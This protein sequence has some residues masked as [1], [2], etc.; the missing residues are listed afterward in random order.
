MPV[1]INMN[2]KLD[3]SSNKCNKSGESDTCCESDTCGEWEMIDCQVD[4]SKQKVVKDPF[5]WDTIRAE[6]LELAALIP[7]LVMGICGNAVTASYPW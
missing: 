3:M 1:T 2:Y 7:S 6:T 5:T 4:V